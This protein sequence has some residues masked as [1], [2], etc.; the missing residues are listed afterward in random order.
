ML[1]WLKNNEIERVRLNELNWKLRE[2]SSDVKVWDND[3]GD[4][5]SVN[6]FNRPPDIP[7]SLSQVTELRNFYRTTVA[8]AGGGI[9][10]VEPI[11]LKGLPAIECLF[12][13]PMQP[14][15]M[16]YLASFTI[17]FRAKSYV[18]KMQCPERGIT[19]AR[20]A[21]VFALHGNFDDEDAENFDPFKGWMKDPYDESV[22]E[23]VL[24]NLSEDE[25]YDV[26]F[27]D[28]PLS[29]ARRYMTQIK[30]SVSFDE[31]LFRLPNFG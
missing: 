19:G 11:E 26:K 1:N 22:T 4:V 25:Q 28:H 10:R 5:L 20:D 27:P 8:G 7:V 30:E 12:K 16:L 6:F 17:P 31:R 21:A 3:F 29:R 23:G 9:I 13:M 18:I 2:K 14:S 24:M 15:G